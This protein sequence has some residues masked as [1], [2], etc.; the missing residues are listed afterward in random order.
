MNVEKKPCF[1]CCSLLDDDPG[2]LG[3]AIPTKHNDTETLARSRQKINAGKS[4]AT[5]NGTK[6]ISKNELLRLG[7]S[8]TLIMC[9]HCCKVF[10]KKGF[11]TPSI[12]GG[13]KNIEYQENIV[14]TACIMKLSEIEL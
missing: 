7:I 6:V 11:V 1:S 9:G 8:P 3:L 12:T 13:L 10:A 4:E 14:T 2:A 5:R